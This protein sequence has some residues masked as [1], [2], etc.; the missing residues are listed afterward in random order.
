MELVRVTSTNWI[1]LIQVV[2]KGTQYGEVVPTKEVEKALIRFL[3][4]LIR[5]KGVQEE[6]V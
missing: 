6:E 5:I 4:N 3:T 1:L 2:I